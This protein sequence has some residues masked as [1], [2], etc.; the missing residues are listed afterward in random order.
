M[1]CWVTFAQEAIFGDKHTRVQLQNGPKSTYKNLR[2]GD[3][4]QNKHQGCSRNIHTDQTRRTPAKGVDDRA[5]R[6][7][8][9][10]ISNKFEFKLIALNYEIGR[11]AAGCV[12]SKN[13]SIGRTTAGRSAGSVSSKNG[14]MFPRRL[15]DFIFRASAGRPA[16]PAGRRFSEFPARNYTGETSLA[17]MLLL[18]G[19]FQRGKFSQ[20]AIFCRL[21]QADLHDR[22][23]FRISFE[24]ICCV[25]MTA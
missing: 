1:V 18:L 25:V 22:T 3:P 7:P 6:I 17:L 24:A 21:L 8:L 20:R 12:C 16:G 10:K 9:W 14:P 2:E 13:G 15:A 23:P 19:E 11:L 4:A 5:Y